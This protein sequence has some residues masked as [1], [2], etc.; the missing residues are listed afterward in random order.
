MGRKRKLTK[1]ELQPLFEK[2]MA[3]ADQ[4]I[5]D[6]DFDFDDLNLSLDALLS[7]P[8]YTPPKVSAVAAAL[9]SLSGTRSI[10][11]RVPAR[12]IHA[13]RVQAAKTGG[14]YQTIMN[15]AL[16]AAAAGYI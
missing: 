8:S 9:P 1:E 14:S 3:V 5:L 15:R 2:I 6:M 11:I 4:P 16:K 10:C 12:V 13:F 7:L